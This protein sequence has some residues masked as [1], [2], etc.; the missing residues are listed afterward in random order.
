MLL[1]IGI[2]FSSVASIGLASP[3]GTKT[4]EISIEKHYQFDNVVSVEIENSL[5]DLDFSPA[6]LTDGINLGVY[7]FRPFAFVIVSHSTEA[8]SVSIR[9]K[10]DPEN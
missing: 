5:C 8:K 9:N 6:I 4:E 3:V 7:T 10:G 2:C 1:A